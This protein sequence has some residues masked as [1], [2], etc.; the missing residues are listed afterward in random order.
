MAGLTEVG[1]AA[2]WVAH[3]EAGKP[4]CVGSG[5]GPYTV[6]L[7]FSKKGKLRGVQ[8]FDIEKMEDVALVGKL[9]KKAVG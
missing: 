8:V 1:P 7:F 3:A 5:G 2:I 6:N 4:V 9:P